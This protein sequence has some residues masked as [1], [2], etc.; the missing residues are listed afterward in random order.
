MLVLGGTGLD[1][2]PP[3]QQALLQEGGSWS[4]A[5]C[6]TSTPPAP[7]YPPPPSSC[8]ATS[9]TRASIEEAVRGCEAVFNCVHTLAPRRAPRP[10]ETFVDTELRGLENVVAA[11]R[12]HVR[13][14]SS[15]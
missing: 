13:A 10:G 3:R 15:T 5:P 4:A 1:R 6:A 11:C 8:A 7:D 12:L 14:A 2:P 9:P